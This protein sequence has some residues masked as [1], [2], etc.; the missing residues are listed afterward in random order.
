MKVGIVGSGFVG[1]TAAYAMVL[2]GVARE[3]VLI[4]LNTARAK[5]EA[6]DISHATP[7]SNPTHIYA[8]DYADLAGSSVVV[9]SAGVGQKPGETRLQ[10]LERNAAVFR[11]VIPRILTHAPNA[12][13]LVTTN[14]VDVM[15]HIAARIAAAHGVPSSRV[16]G[17]GTVLD[18]GRFQSLLGRYLDV[19]PHHI[20][21]YVLGEHG[22]SE[23]I[24]WSAVRVG[25]LALEDFSRKR[26]II[27]DRAIRDEI[28]HRVR[29]A[30]YSIIE[31]KAAT[32]YGIG[33]ALAEIVDGIL[34]NRRLIMTV[35]TPV[36]EVA[37]VAD[38]TVSLPHLVGGSGVISSFPPNL[39]DEEQTMLHRS[40]SII[41]EAIDELDAAEHD[42]AAK[43]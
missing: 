30:A 9:I 2:Q 38:V 21:G 35:C 4:D 14:P 31:H 26:G 23:V 11:S 20:H 36:P 22:D 3:I 19:D 15:T 39:N 24:A 18:T 40:A 42:R 5:A 16:I 32:Y 28:G 17:S 6:D 29:D 1:A 33:A 7:F 41:R 10:L 12:V 27:L 37:G 8:G 13:L 43:E 34:D 25:N